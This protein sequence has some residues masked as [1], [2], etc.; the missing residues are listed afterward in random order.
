MESQASHLK[1]GEAT[2]TLAKQYLLNEG[3][4]LVEQN[5]RALS[6]E[7]DLIMMHDECLVFIEVRYRKS[8]NFG[9]ALESITSSKQAKIR[10]TALYYLQKNANM[11][12]KECRFDV[13]AATGKDETFEIQWLANAFQ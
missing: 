3:L 4:L 1:M 13:I 10:K 8:Q 7:I 6:G 5:F 2:E 12:F 9:G 11:P